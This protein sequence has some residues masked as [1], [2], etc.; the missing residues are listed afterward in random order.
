MKYKL[1]NKL[2]PTP[3][4]PTAFD[5]FAGCGGLSQ[6]LS[7]AGFDV[8]W[9]NEYWK[10][11]AQTYRTSHSSTTLFEEDA[12]HLLTRLIDG[13]AGLPS[14]GEVDLLAG[15]PPC[16]GFSG[17]NRH[18]KPEDPRNSML[19]VFLGFVRHLKPRMVLIENVP[20]LLTLDEGKLA[21]LLLSSFEELGYKSKVGLLQAGYYGIPQNRWRTFVVATSDGTAIPSF[22][23]PTHEFPRI[24]IHGSAK[25]KV[26]PEI[27]KPNPRSS[28]KL[29][30]FNSVTVGDAISDLPR[31]ASTNPKE[32]CEYASQPQSD[33]QRLLRKGSRRVRDHICP[34]VE[35]V[36]LERICA[37]P[38]KPGAGWL[39]LPER[40]KPA[41]LKRHG[42]SRYANRYGRLD[43]AT[44]FNTILTRPHPYWSRV[45][46]PEEN[47]L[48]SVRECARAQSFFDSTI[49]C[50][51]MSEKFKQIGNAVPPLLA[52]KMGE[53]LIASLIVTNTNR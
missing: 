47:R 33:Y 53:A 43:W 11:A 35:P 27:I 50:G 5:L 21:Q 6:G 8:R 7:R 1:S 24:I 14:P 10:P 29:E 34:K 31:L 20:G 39:D 38:R 9:A 51:T 45:I 36:T 37:V 52:E 13:E 42:D 15:G 32:D 48:L 41:N 3:L 49:F 46:H 26:Q 22:P 12:R 23:L 19:D 40:L 2:K 17:F 44:I 18:R 28:G 4:R 25:I 16:Q 30:L